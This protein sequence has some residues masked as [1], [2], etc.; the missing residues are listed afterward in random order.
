MSCACFILDTP[1]DILQLPSDI[2][3]QLVPECDNINVTTNTLTTISLTGRAPVQCYSEILSNVTFVNHGDEPG[4]TNRTITFDLVDDRG[5]SFSASTLVT[6]IATNDPAI[7]SFN[8]TIVTFSEMART[9]V[10][11][12]ELNDTLIDSDGDSLQWLSVEIRPSIDEMDVLSADPGNSNL[13]IRSSTNPDNNIVLTISG[14]AS[15]SVYE[16]VLQ[17]LTFYNPFPGINLTNRSIH[18]ETFDGETL[19]PSTVI[20]VYID[21]FDDVS[22]CFF[23]NSLVSIAYSKT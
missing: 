4:N 3:S 15:F 11:L 2:T 19:S 7:F 20:T 17:T 16:T 13:V 14:Y 12:F 22:A 9:P 23:G 21:P 8:N 5:F 1:Q 10:N 6:I 18:I